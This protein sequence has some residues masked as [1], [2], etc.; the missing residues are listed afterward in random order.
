MTPSVQVGASIDQILAAEDEGEAE[1]QQKPAKP[2]TD[3]Q[4]EKALSVLK[5]KA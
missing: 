3:E 4:L 2:M 1:T 5:S